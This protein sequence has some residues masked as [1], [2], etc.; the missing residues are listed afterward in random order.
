MPDY[1]LGLRHILSSVISGT[2]AATLVTGA[3][4]AQ[5]RKFSFVE[6]SIDGIH[7]ALRTDRLSCVQLVQGY[8]DRISAYDQKGPAF[9]AVQ[10]V[11]SNALKLA[12]EMDVSF[13]PKAPMKPLFCIPVVVKDQVE[14]SFLPTTF[15]SKLFKDFT[16][17]RTATI[18]ERMMNAGAIVIAKTNLGEFAAGGSGSAFGDCRNVYNPSYYAS[19]S[20]C[21]TGIAVAANFATVGIGEDTAGSTRGPASHASVVGLRPTLPLVSRFGAMPQGPSRDTLGPMARTVR[22]TAILLDVIAGYDP[23]DPIT[24]ESYG[25]LPKSYTDFLVEGGLK[26]MRIGVIRQP[27]DPRTDTKSEAY[28]KVKTLVDRGV[29]DM[30]AAAAEIVDAVEIP[31]LMDLLAASGS[32]GS[33]YESE[34]AINAYLA[35]H[36]NA[37]I[38]TYAEIVNSSVVIESRRKAMGPD[39]G[40]VPTDPAFLLQ[41]VK[42]AELRTAILKTMADQKLDALFYASFDSPPVLLPGSTPYSNRLMATF[43]GLPALAVPGGFTADGLPVGVEFFGRAFDEGTIFKAAY[44]FEQATRYRQPPKLAP[45][46]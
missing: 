26:G 41:L 18:V 30:R 5:D 16:P 23:N 22:D 42:R 44:G 24:S 34:Q 14:T 29:A 20:S 28:Q 3:A 12:K 6:A 2:V 10:N 36:P 13:D 43:T 35:Q 17:N 8:L 39:L 1:R 38:K 19:G 11:N 25:K 9:N 7:E 46:L 37:P 33:P 21:G 4:L 31:N 40:G 45:E 32:N 27:M 15:G